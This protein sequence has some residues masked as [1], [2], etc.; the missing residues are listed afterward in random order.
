MIEM[1]VEDNGIGMPKDF[2][3]G[4]SKSLGLHLVYI[5]VKDQLGGKIKLD[6]R[7]GTKFQVTI[8]K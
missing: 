8:K 7:G 4:K 5:L 3:I 6:R 2:N 1:V